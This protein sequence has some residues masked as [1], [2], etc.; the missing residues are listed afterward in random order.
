[1]LV[2]GRNEGQKVMLTLPSGEVIAVSVVAVRGKKA[3]LGFESPKNVSI[4]REEVFEARKKDG[5][6]HCNS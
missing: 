2:L 4:D 6:E 5:P 1:M 3:R